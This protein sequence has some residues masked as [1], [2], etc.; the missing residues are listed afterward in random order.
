MIH[1]TKCQHINTESFVYLGS[2]N[3][4]A[5]LSACFYV[6]TFADNL[7]PVNSAGKLCLANYQWNHYELEIQQHPEMCKE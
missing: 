3:L 2:S 5:V 4:I 6:F 1:K 7:C